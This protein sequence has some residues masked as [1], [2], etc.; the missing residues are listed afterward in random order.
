MTLEDPVYKHLGSQANFFAQAAGQW[1]A[2]FGIRV[3]SIRYVFISDNSV[4][5]GRN[6][7]AVF[8]DAKNAL[9]QGALD[10]VLRSYVR[11]R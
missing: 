9:R 6:L 2:I 11:K 5:I 3:A 8:T 10:E 4:G 1:A 7:I